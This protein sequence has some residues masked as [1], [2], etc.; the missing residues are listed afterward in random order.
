MDKK[1]KRIFILRVIGWLTLSCILPVVFI[2]WR[3][4]LFEGNNS[5]Q[6]SGWGLIAVIIIAVFLYTLVRYIRAGFTEWSMLKQIVN[7]IVR[8]L[9]PLAAILAIVVSIRNSVETFIQALSCVLIC[10][11]ISIPLNPFPEWIWKKS[12]GKFESTVDYIADRL[13]QGKKEDKE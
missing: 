2:G 13:N 11:V 3:F 5:L 8:I 6:L 1:E 7:G 10:E 4:K 12:K 9:L